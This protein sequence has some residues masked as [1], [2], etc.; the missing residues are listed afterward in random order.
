LRN[1]GAGLQ[2]HPYALKFLHAQCRTCFTGLFLAVGSVLLICRRGATGVPK[3]WSRHR[4]TPL[5]PKFLH[6]MCRICYIS[7]YLAVGVRLAYLPTSMYR[8]CENVEETSNAFPRPTN[9]FRPHAGPALPAH[10]WRWVPPSFFAGVEIRVF[11]NCG[12]GLQN[13]NY[14]LKILNAPC[15]T[16]FTGLTWLWGLSSLFAGV[17]VRVSLNGGADTQTQVRAHNFQHP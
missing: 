5:H 15:R 6:G 17:E 12:A 14:T 9:S 4:K 2:S 8:C 10:T 7:L 3:W 16:C 1:C 13:H 11:R